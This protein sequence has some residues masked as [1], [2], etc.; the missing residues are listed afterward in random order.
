MNHHLFIEGII[1]VYLKKNNSYLSL[2]TTDATVSAFTKINKIKL[3][4]IIHAPK[5]C[6]QI[7]NSD[8]Q[9]GTLFGPSLHN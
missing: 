1:R 8:R 2:S 5:L 4:D 7:E 9:A 3:E 6:S